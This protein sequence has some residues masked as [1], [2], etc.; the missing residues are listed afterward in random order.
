[1]MDFLL[2]CSKCKYKKN[3]FKFNDLWL[4]FYFDPFCR[5]PW[6]L[7]PERII[8]IYCFQLA[9]V[10]M[11]QIQE[12]LLLW[13]HL[14]LDS[15]YLLFVLSDISIRSQFYSFAYLLLFFSEILSD[16]C[17]E[18]ANFLFFNAFTIYNEIKMFANYQ[19]PLTALK[20][21]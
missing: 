10:L 12:H 15:C 6:T 11:A 2:I 9:K 16:D 18:K 14:K 3:F 4:I 20:Y 21:D 1:M 8:L 19:L 5:G 17:P 7:D 13:I